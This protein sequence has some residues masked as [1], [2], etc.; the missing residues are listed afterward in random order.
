MTVGSKKPYDLVQDEPW[1]FLDVR[2]NPVSGRKLTFR[3]TDG[4]MIEVDVTQAEYKSVDAIRSKL[5][6]EIAA[7]EAAK[8]L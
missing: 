5:M 1:T 6:T 3:L 8:A 4:T 2:H 7:H